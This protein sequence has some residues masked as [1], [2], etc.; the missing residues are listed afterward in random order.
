MNQAD[1]NKETA[2]LLAIKRT[3]ALPFVSSLIKS[4]ADLNFKNSNGKTALEVYMELYN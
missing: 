3:P 1:K 2:I 4:K